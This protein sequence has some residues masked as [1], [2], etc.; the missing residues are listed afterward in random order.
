MGICCALRRIQC[1]HVHG[2]T[3]NLD[4]LITSGMSRTTGILTTLSLDC[5]IASKLLQPVVNPGLT[6]CFSALNT[7]FKQNRRFI[8]TAGGQVSLN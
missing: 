1:R 6:W 5:S 2:I 3:E 7:M 8:K 4:V